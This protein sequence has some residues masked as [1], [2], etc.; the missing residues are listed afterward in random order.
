MNTISRSTLID[1]DVQERKDETAEA[2]KQRSGK[3]N[4]DIIYVLG[5][6]DGKL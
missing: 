4:R 5:N 1:F 6:D 3:D 2:Q